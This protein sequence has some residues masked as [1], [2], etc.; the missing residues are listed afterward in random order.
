MEETNFHRKGL[1]R[2]REKTFRGESP[3]LHESPEEGSPTKEIDTGAELG[4]S[5]MVAKEDG[6]VSKGKPKTFYNRLRIFDKTVL[7]HP[8]RLKDMVIRPIIFLSF[9]VIS[10]A[11]F[12]YGSNI[13]WFNVLNGTTSLI[14]SANPYGFGSSIVGLAYIAPF[15]GMTIGY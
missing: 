7:Q 3:H 6:Y 10:Y 13:V 1:T 5:A 14:L 8:N 2:S 12:S 4:V 9:P 15:I 11:G